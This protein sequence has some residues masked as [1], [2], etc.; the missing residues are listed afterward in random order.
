MSTQIKQNQI[1]TGNG[2]LKVLTVFQVLHLKTQFSSVPKM[3]ANKSQAINPVFVTVIV[4]YFYLLKLNN[5]HPQNV[6]L[7]E[8]NA[9]IC[10]SFLLIL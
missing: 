4:Q 8:A 10:I 1:N 5:I 2:E 3:K 6:R 9:G 7:G